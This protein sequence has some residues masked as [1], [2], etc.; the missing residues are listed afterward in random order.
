MTKEDLLRKGKALARQG[1]YSAATE[2]FQEIVCGDESNLDAWNGLEESYRKLGKFDKAQECAEKIR[3]LT[4]VLPKKV[5]NPA[6]SNK[7]ATN[8]RTFS[9]PPKT[10]DVQKNKRW[11]TALI[12]ANVFYFVS[13]IISVFACIFADWYADWFPI[14]F[15]ILIVVFEILFFVII[16]SAY[17]DSLKGFEDSDSK[18]YYTVATLACTIVFACFAIKL[19]AGLS[20]EI[21]EKN[22]VQYYRE[23]VQ[24]EK[25]EMMQAIEG[26]KHSEQKQKKLF[27]GLCFGMTQKEVDSVLNSEL[28]L[29]IYI[30]TTDSERVSV[31]TAFFHGELYKVELSSSASLDNLLLQDVGYQKYRM[32]FF[33]RF[34]PSDSVFVKDNLIV[35][36]RHGGY[37]NTLS[38]INAPILLAIEEEWEQEREQERIADSIRRDSIRQE[39]LR[40]QRIEIRDKLR[41][42]SINKAR[43]KRTR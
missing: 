18:V 29:Y 8:G 33:D 7:T 23:K 25:E 35:E 43:F 20:R 21:K 1:K 10:G 34:H 12:V 6:Q 38:Y 30:S 15:I 3:Q 36:S 4:T 24:Q 28:P 37:H 2:Y 14:G 22:R 26:A 13:S 39:T 41:L 5:Q 27:C 9:Q 16:P 19:V 42:D 32:D 17:P 31:D 11:A 40:Q